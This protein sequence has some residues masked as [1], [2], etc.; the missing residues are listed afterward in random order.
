M[1]YIAASPAQSGPE[2][3]QM[4]LSL[5]RDIKARLRIPVAVKLSPLFTAFAHFAGQPVLTPVT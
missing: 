2:V 4:Y 1:Y 5:V 3:E